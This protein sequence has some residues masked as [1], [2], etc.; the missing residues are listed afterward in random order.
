MLVTAINNGPDDATGV[1]LEFDIGNSFTYMGLD[2]RGHGTAVYNNNN[3]TITWTPGTIPNQTGASLVV[4]LKVHSIRR[5]NTKPNNNLQFNKRRPNRHQPNK[6]HIKLRHKHRPI[7]RHRSKPNIQHIHKQQQNIHNLHNNNQQ[8]RTRQRN[9]T[10]NKRQT[11]NRTNIHKQ[12][13][14]KR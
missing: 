4:Y 2:T 7:T 5:Q 9:R 1:K 10:T 6:Q 3:N 12:P 8:Q 14:I 13:T 11:T